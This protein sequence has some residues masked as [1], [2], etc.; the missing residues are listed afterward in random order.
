MTERNYKYDNIRIF[1]MALVIL[2]HL[3]YRVHNHTVTN[4][5]LIIYSFHMP[6]FIFLTGLFAKWN[7]KKWI[8]NYV[9]TYLVFQLLYPPFR[10]FIVHETEKLKFK[11]LHPNY[12]LWYLLCLIMFVPLVPLLAKLVDKKPR[13]R[14]ACLVICIIAATLCGYITYNN[15][16][17]SWRRYICYLPYFVAGYF[18]GHGEWEQQIKAR[19]LG[20]FEQRPLVKKTVLTALVI[21]AAFV[22]GFTKLIRRSM[23]WNK[24]SY[25]QTKGNPMMFLGIVV[26]AF[27]WIL[28]LSVM[29]PSKQIPVIS[30]LG[31]RT[32]PIYLLHGFIL[33]YLNY[34]HFFR[35]GT[36]I[37]VLLCILMTFVLIA[38]LGNRYVYRAFMKVG[39]A[40]FLFPKERKEK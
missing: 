24:F 34:I 40:S 13:V 20:F 33:K 39:V 9:Y 36:R 38:L 7:F 31:Q 26:I 18:V 15:K 37:N 16:I 30:T 17:L 4:F 28:W 35:F 32:Y 10:Y 2:G 21:L 6:A 3:L 22:V 19:V 27:L 25:A 8:S 12:T 29:M 23:Y 1:L 11:P 14:I 5:Y